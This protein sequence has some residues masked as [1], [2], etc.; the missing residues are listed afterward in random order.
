MTDTTRAKFESAMITLGYPENM[1]EGAKR[2]DSWA[3]YDPKAFSMWEAYQAA[4]SQSAPDVVSMPVPWRDRESVSS[5]DVEYMTR[6]ARG[7]IEAEIAELRAA[8]ASRDKDAE[9]V[10]HRPS[11]AQDEDFLG[12]DGPDNTQRSSMAKERG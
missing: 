5:F 9:L 12:T 4:L 10:I 1:F 7:A 6:F 3:Y 8:L 2:H 11:D